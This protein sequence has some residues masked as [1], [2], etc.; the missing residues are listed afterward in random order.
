[1]KKLL[2]YLILLLVGFNTK[3]QVTANFSMSDSVFCTY[4]IVQLTDMSSPSGLTLE[5][6][7]SDGNTLY[8]YATYPIVYALYYAAGTYAIKL[9]VTD[10]VFTDSIVKNITILDH[11]FAN[12]SYFPSNPTT[13]DTVQFTNLSTHANSYHW[14]FNWQ[15]NDTS[16]L[17]NPKHLYDTAGNY[18]VWLVAINDS[19]PFLVCNDTHVVQIIYQSYFSGRV[20]KRN[21]F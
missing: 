7:L 11:P 13:N 15:M 17:E 16:T 2:F 12:F 18:Y 4:E 8:P 20:F 19:L 10:G 6:D 21:C 3:A 5:W 14:N 1:M 9:K